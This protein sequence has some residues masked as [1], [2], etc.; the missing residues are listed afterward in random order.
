MFILNDN[1]SEADLA[2]ERERL[3]RRLTQLF[4]KC[5]GEGASDLLL[6]SV[7]HYRLGTDT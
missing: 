5:S 2:A 6:R 3:E 4:R 1:I 7:K